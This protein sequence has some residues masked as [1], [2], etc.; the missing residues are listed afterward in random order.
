MSARRPIGATTRLNVRRVNRTLSRTI[1]L[2]ILY[3]RNI[4]IICLPTQIL[5][6]A[7]VVTLST[8]GT[9]TLVVL[10]AI[11]LHT[12]TEGAKP[13][14]AHNTSAHRRTRICSRC[15]RWSCFLL[16]LPATYHSTTNSTARDAQRS[17]WPDGATQ[18]P[19]FNS[20]QNA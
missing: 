13:S 4:R 7:G 12:R 15:L 10:S 17:T 9:L 8:K 3:L 16:F 20:E 14:L 2:L 18:P 11:I 5:R 6:L 1:L 19:P